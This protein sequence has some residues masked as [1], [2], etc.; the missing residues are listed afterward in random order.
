MSVPI[1]KQGKMLI[2]T[3][4]PDMTDKDWI[5]F[6]SEV[7]RLVGVHRSSGV[8]LDVTVLD[9]LDS[10]AT[11]SL[12]NIAEMVKLRGS[13]SVVVGIHPDVAFSMVQLGLTL[14]GIETGIDLEHGLAILSSAI[15]RDATINGRN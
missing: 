13:R 14:Q 4:Q 9:V 11:K 1:L 12:K 6:Q 10:F 3:L 5:S 2:A 7:T 15:A 8:I